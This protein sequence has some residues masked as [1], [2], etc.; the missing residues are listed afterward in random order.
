MEDRFFAN[1]GPLEAWKDDV[2]R[3]LES[4]RQQT[5]LRLSQYRQ[6]TQR[7]AVQIQQ[8]AAMKASETAPRSVDQLERRIGTWLTDWQSSIKVHLQDRDKRLTT[9]IH[10]E[11]AALEARTESQLTR[12]E[13]QTI[14][15]QA[16]DEHFNRIALAVR[17]LAES[18]SATPPLTPGSSAP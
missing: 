13:S 14:D 2:Q 9:Q 8:V 7:L 12:L 3:L 6:E 16:L 4:N 5:D 1:P 17:A 18:V 11:V 10:N 15:R